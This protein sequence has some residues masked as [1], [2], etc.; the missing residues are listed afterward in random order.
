MRSKKINKIVV[1]M[2]ILASISGAMFVYQNFFLNKQNENVLIYLAKEDIPAKTLVTNEM[3]KAVNMPKNG[4]LSNYVT[5][6]GEINGKELKGGLLKDE[7]LSKSRLTT[8]QENSLNLEVKLESDVSIPL[9]NNDYVNVYVVLKDSQ[10]QVE[11]R[12]IFDT[13]Q[14]KI[15]GVGQD[16][17]GGT[18]TIMSIKVTDEELIS[19]YDAKE[20][21]KVIIAKNNNID[22]GKDITNEKY[23]PK[24]DEAQNAV[25][26]EGNKDNAVSIVE[27][28]FEEGDTLE[29]L[30]IKYKT[31]IE[32]IKKLNNNKEEFAVGENIVLPAN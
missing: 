8:K 13:K 14:V 1:T 19:Y 22:G 16:D 12:K 15:E 32:E 6:I 24:S 9:K 4:V 11:V 20:R 10:N 17:A 21:G 18:E 26:D 27:K 28:Q 31:T 30:S 25:K 5:N 2:G 7:P 3:F 29:S 23:D